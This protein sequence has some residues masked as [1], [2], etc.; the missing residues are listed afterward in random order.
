[1]EYP[2]TAA[3]KLH[4][5]KERAS[6][7]ADL[8]HSIINT[9]SV[10]HVSFVP[11]PSTAVPVILPMIG[12]IGLY[13]GSNDDRPRCYLHGSISA[14]LMRLPSSSSSSSS[15]SAPNT[16]DNPSENGTAGAQR[17]AS[18]ILSIPVCIA[19][20]KVDGY[21]LAL[22]PFSH[23]YNYR[24]V[25][26]HGRASIV[27]DPGEKMFAFELVTNGVVPGRWENS[28]VPPEPSEI[29][30]TQILAVEIETASAKVREGGPKEERRDAKNEAV[31][32]RVWTGVV[33]VAEQFGDAIPA[34]ENV[35]KQVPPYLKEFLAKR[36]RTN[37]E[38]A[39][40]V[41]RV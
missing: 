6:Y 9:T 17:A 37:W 7:D 14:R 35:A 11:D 29:K 39:E 28:R 31:R 16:L 12:Q 5:R 21:V 30:S 1:M 40:G 36:N 25:V 3:S 13:P 22:T 4:R 18:E 10:L 33:P 15:S 24:S 8:I 20:T 38:E 34:Q 23:S 26:L 2:V 32:G 41:A 19:A 27:T